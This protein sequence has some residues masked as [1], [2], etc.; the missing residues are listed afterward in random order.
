MT[1][2]ALPCLGLYLMLISDQ[3]WGYLMALID[4][5]TIVLAFILPLRQSQTGWTGQIS[6]FLPGAF[7]LIYPY[8]SHLLV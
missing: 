7:A 5:D 3:S 8:F 1:E 2:I 4:E 6:K